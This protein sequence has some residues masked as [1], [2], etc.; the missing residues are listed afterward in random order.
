MAQN[1]SPSAE[2]LST[3]RALV[4]VDVQNDFCPGGSLATA[5]GAQVAQ[6]I[7]NYLAQHA[8]DYQEIV[9]TQDW[10][11]NPAE[12]FCAPGEEPNFRTTWPVH[13]Q[14]DSPGAQFHPALA[15]AHFDEIFRKGAYT[16]A[17]SGFEG[18][19]TSDGATP[20]ADWLRQRDIAHVDVVGIATDFCVHATARD[21]LREGFEVRLL[22]NHCAAV[23]EEGGREALAELQR[24]GATL[25]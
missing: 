9:A 17:Y 10:H 19:A 13:C 4:V 18:E 22:A 7:A 21:A 1:T 16:A 24:E 11:I 15:G 25:A 5:R 2:E 14:A 3:G 23:S 20:L 8:G 6:S 12:H